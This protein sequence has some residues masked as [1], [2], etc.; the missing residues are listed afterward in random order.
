MALSSDPAMRELEERL[1]KVEKRKIE[2]KD[3]PLQALKTTILGAEPQDPT[4]FLLPKSV[5]SDVL[6]E[7]SVTPS[8]IGPP[9]PWITPLMENSWAQYTDVNY[10]NVAYKTC[11]DGRVQLRGG[12]MHPAAGAGGSTIFTLPV[13]LRPELNQLFPVMTNNGVE[14]L[15]VFSNGSISYGGVAGT[16]AWLFLDPVSFYPDK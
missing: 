7:D 15:N 9:E 16:I 5:T 6:A 1:E 8:A 3:L 11:L 12:V 14:R 10:A 13:G 2:V 4:T